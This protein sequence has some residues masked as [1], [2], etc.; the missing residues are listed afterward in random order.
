MRIISGDLKG[1]RLSTP[2]NNKVRPTTDKI[3]ES[4]FN[5][6]MEYTEDAVVLDLFSGTGN[7]G[8][9]AISRG[10]AK[11][12]FSDKSKESLQ[13]TIKN[14]QHCDVKDKSVAI[15]GDYQVALN[16]ISD[17]IDIVFVDPPY[18]PGIIN[19]CIADISKAGILSEDGIIIAEHDRKDLLPETINNLLKYKEKRYG[20]ISITIYKSN[21]EEVI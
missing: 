21:W 13:L 11:C 3:K 7:L 5:M 17:K 9:E 15:L 18:E 16:K 8:L 20:A 6:I 14:I 2:N 19:K 10:A 4:I 12:Y 1:K